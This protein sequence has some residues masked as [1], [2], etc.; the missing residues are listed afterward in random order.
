[1]PALGERVPRWGNRLTRAFGRA[2]L[3]LVGWRVDG[4]IP[5]REKLLAISA[6]HTTAWDL[7]I[8]LMALVAIGIRGSWMGAD[9]IFRIPLMRK[10]GGVPID[11]QARLGVVAQTIES[12]KNRRQFALALFPEGSRKKVVPWKTGFY[13]IAVGAEVPIL[14]VVVDQ[15]AKRMTIGP[16]FEPCGDYQADMDEHIRP[17]YARFADQYPDQFGI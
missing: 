13:R 14:L 9:W 6:P 10:I 15:Q 1:M 16:T 17:V 7:P 2:V 3:R 12:Y 5:N 4:E 8:C 11:R